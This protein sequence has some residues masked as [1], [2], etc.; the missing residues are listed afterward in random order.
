VRYAVPKSKL[1]DLIQRY[2]NMYRQHVSQL[3]KEAEDLISGSEKVELEY[4]RTFSDEFA[5]FW[6]QTF[7]DRILSRINSAAVRLYLVL[8]VKQEEAAKRNQWGL[9]LTDA[10]I[11]REL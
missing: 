9:S 1:L 2:S 10:A 7:D 4:T 11:A 8:L 6:P 5:Y 3:I